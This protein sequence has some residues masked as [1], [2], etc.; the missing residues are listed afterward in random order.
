MDNNW[1]IVGI[2]LQKDNPERAEIIK[3][4]KSIS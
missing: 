3:K 2:D 4:I 1:K